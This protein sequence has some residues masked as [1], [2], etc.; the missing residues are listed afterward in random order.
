MF[1]DI[2]RVIEVLSRINILIN[3]QSQFSSGKIGLGDCYGNDS[4]LLQ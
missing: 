3:K 4:I 2:P 1:R